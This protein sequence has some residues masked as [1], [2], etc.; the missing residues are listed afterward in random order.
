MLVRIEHNALTGTMQEIPVD[1]A[2]IL[3]N[4][5]S[6]V[7]LSANDLSL[8]VGE[9]LTLSAQ[10]YTPPLLDGNRQ[11]LTTAL[12]IEIQLGDIVQSVSLVNGQWSDS[13][14]FVAA[15][16]YLIYCLSHPSNQVSIE[17]S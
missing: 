1:D 11:A 5:P 3:A 2:W 6:Q 16:Q 10:L 8:A 14:Q 15:G 12:S 4:R 9:S 7:E 17:V 13:I